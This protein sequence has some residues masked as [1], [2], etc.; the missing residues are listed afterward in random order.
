MNLHRIKSNGFDSLGTSVR[1]LILENEPQDAEL[2]LL[3]LQRFGYQ[4]DAALAQNHSEYLRAL[5]KDYDVILADYS[6]TQFTAEDALAILRERGL[7]IPLIIVT[8]SVGEETAAGCIKQGAAD[9]LLKDRLG[10]LGQAVKQA[11]RERDLRREQAKTERELHLKNLA[12][13]SSFN[14][15]ALTDL[16]GYLTYVNHAFLKLWGYDHESEVL[17]QHN[18]ILAAKDVVEAINEA[19]HLQG[20]WQGEVV[21]IRKDLR[22]LAIQ[23]SASMIVDE[24]GSP[25]G[26]MGTFQDIGE[27]KRAEQALRQS[28]E[29]VRT[30]IDTVMDAIIISDERGVIEM[31]NPATTRMF[32]YSVEELLGKNVKILMTATDR[33][34][35]H[36]YMRNYIN[37]GEARIIGKGREVEGKRK[38]ESVF[39]LEFALSEIYLN[40]QRFFVA[41]M[42]DLTERKQAEQARHEAD[43]MRLELL[44]A[45][46]MRK[47]KGSFVSM[48]THEFRNPLAGIQLN[49][50]TLLNYF[51]RLSPQQRNQ[52]LQTI[53]EQVKN[54]DNL[55]EDILTVG[56][57]EAG[58]EIPFNPVLLDLRAFCQAIFEE[59]VSTVGRRHEMV[60]V[61]DFKELPF[62]F[63]PKL[64]RQI[65]NNLLTN[66]TKYSPENSLV[67]MELHRHLDEVA[68]T[69]SDQG[70]GIPEEDQKQ[71]FD[72]FHR[73]ENA[74][75]LPGSGLGLAIVKQAVDMHHGTVSFA[76]TPGKG[77]TFVVTL[78]FKPGK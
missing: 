5:D 50:S 67:Q 46:E 44:K 45:N 27:R 55:L 70:M 28:E 22:E 4:V 13:A 63:D 72:A 7:D 3:E 64:M 47:L 57:D 77:T 38:D 16:D 53:V 9:Y 6:L 10:R 48:V 29:R 11:M 34:Q 36:T 59:I 73:A 62:S 43:V 19:L 23:V 76:S 51:D 15:V 31:V 41:L 54:M 40:N 78:P 65:V 30:I 32:G 8:G 1:V 2:M 66:S 71:I 61:A 69:V 52:K 21:I 26:L 14:A 35:H 24:T 68:I 18:T 20:Y 39:P 42:H 74:Y 17:G 12:L 37:T 33:D 25:I 49:A 60:F 56:Q 75:K 58:V